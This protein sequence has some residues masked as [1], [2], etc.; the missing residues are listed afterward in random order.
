MLFRSYRDM[1][2]RLL[3]ERNDHSIKAMLSRVA[4]SNESTLGRMH[5][6]WTMEGMGLLKPDLLMT[7]IV[8]TNSI[9]RTQAIRLIE[10][11]VANDNALRTKIG[12]ILQKSLPKA[13][14]KELL[15]ISLSANV[16][17]KDASLIILTGILR[18][19]DTSALIRDAILSSLYHREFE[20]FQL[21]MKTNWKEKESLSKEIF[22]EMLTTAMIRNRN[23]KEL[24][25]LF[26]MIYSYESL[27]W[28]TST[29]LNAI[30][31]QGFNS[32]FNPV[33]LSSA[34]HILT[35]TPINYDSTKIKI[36]SK[37][38]AWPGHVVDKSSGSVT[39]LNEAI[40]PKQYA[41]GRQHFLSSCA[42]C[43]GADG[44]GVNRF[45]P[46]L[47]GSDWV[48][49]NEKRL[50]L[51]L[52]HGIEGP[53]EVNGKVYDAPEILPV[54]PSHAILDDTEIAAIISYIRNE[55]GNRA[56]P[57][58]GRLVGGARIMT[59]GRVMPW[60]AR[61]LNKHIQDTLVKPK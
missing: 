46:S 4:L 47:I 52:L 57:V 19:M 31:I 34:P 14:D 21:L 13:T 53:I 38:F 2:Q 11:F 41:L 20:F 55:W 42:G 12:V 7:L 49:G 16:L 32:K 23:S 35:N 17:N 54:M 50:S 61:E 9:I 30:A 43:H 3:V 29:I 33:S 56:A 28:Y 51:L 15:Q 27:K 40:D 37:M 8:D 26:S 24:T 59:Q 60:T 22:L 48:L 18:Q 45:A 25:E 1:A 10:Q 36:I 6:L 5:A 39:S 44:A 58:T